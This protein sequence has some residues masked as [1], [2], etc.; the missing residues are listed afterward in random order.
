[1]KSSLDLPEARWLPLPIHARSSSDGRRLAIAGQTGEVS[2]V[3][4]RDD[5]VLLRS[6]EEEEGEIET[7]VGLEV[8]SRT[9]QD[10]ALSGQEVT[11]ICSAA[12]TRTGG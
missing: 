12:P 5:E 2:I 11:Q 1:M 7:W 4:L 10:L 3:D 9:R 6:F 8:D